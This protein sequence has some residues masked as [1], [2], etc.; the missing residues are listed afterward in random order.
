MSEVF[1]GLLVRTSFYLEERS[2]RNRTLK[3]SQNA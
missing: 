2:Y 3:G 1:C